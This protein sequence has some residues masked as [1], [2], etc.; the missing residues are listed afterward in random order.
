MSDNLSKLQNIPS[1]FEIERVK[2]SKKINGK[3]KPVMHKQIMK[4]SNKVFIYS[5]FYKSNG[6]KI[7]G[8]LMEPRKGNNLPCVI[9]NR[10]GSRDF[11]A[12]KEGRMFSSKSIM[13]Q[14]AEKGYMVIMTQYPGV[15]GG[16]GID[17]MGSENDIASILDLKKI[18]NKYARADHKNIGMYGHSRG[19]T[20]TYM[21]LRK[22]KWIKAAIIVAG[23][24]DY[25]KKKEF[26]PKMISHYKKMFGGSVVEKKK[27]S[28]IFWADELPKKTPLLL[29]HGTSD[30]RVNPE[31]S[32]EMSQQLYKLKIPSR[33]ILY[34]GDDH[35]INEHRK[36]YQNEALSWFQRFL[37]N[38][39]SI[40]NMKPHGD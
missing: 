1:I 19:G 9:Y 22:V 40:P 12:L 16:D 4:N 33:L 13:F 27:R 28:A 6:Q 38:K 24:A 29:M 31:D 2:L 18:I 35:G 8:Y 21:C 20:M 39:E 5:F 15:D 17:K 26:R 37:I 3:Y 14:L 34:E 32:I 10:G 23:T 7:K 11:G 36:E 30:W 25:I